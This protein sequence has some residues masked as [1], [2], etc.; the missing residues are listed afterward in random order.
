MKKLLLCILI[1]YGLTYG[2]ELPSYIPSTPDVAAMGKFV[3]APVG[4]YTGV[5]IVSVPLASISQGDI[6]IPVALNYHASGIRVDELASCAGLGWSTSAGG[7]VSRSVRGIPDDAVSGYINADMTVDNFL[8]LPRLMTNDPFDQSTAGRLDFESDVYTFSLP[9]GVSGKF[10]FNQNGS[11]FEAVK[12]KD[13]IIEYTQKLGKITQWKIT[14]P[15][16]LV[17]HLG[18]S[19]DGSRTAADKMTTV[20]LTISQNVSTI[21]DTPE[22]LTDYISSWHVM[23]VENSKGDTVSY[24]YNK[25]TIGYYNLGSERKIIWRLGTGDDCQFGT[26]K[27]YLHTLATTHHISQINTQNAKIVYGYD[28]EREDLKGD[29]ALTS[30]EVFD[31]NDTPITTYQFNY[32]YF[33]STEHLSELPYGDLDQ[34]RKRLYLQ[35]LTQTSGTLENQKYSFEYHSKDVL[36]DRLSMAKDFWGYYNG[37]SN[38]ELTP[39][40]IYNL[41]LNNLNDI[42]ITNPS[43]GNK[44]RICNGATYRQ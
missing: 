33:I 24:S 12:N 30:L 27:S 19:K 7:S 28:L 5:P 21:P 43:G 23:E 18:T 2:Q 25:N 42:I 3:D 8:A 35:S 14:T 20:P 1:H 29:N 32:D 16:G 38:T 41:D 11:V 15:D 44:Y 39:N 22:G 31:H 13:L 40:I 37:R 34:R 6:T 17:Y 9:N 10:Y 26:T 4:H 36:P